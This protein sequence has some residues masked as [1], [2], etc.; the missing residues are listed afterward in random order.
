RRATVTAIDVAPR[1]REDHFA[2]RFTGYLTAPATGD[3]TI[4]GG[5][6]DCVWIWLDEQLV[7]ENAKIAP[8]RVVDRKV[9]LDAGA[10]ALR[11]VFP[12]AEGEQQRAVRWSGPGFAR[13]PIPAGALSHRAVALT[14]PSRATLAH[15]APPPTESAAAPPNGPAGKAWAELGDGACPRS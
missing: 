6:D 7:L 3:Y 9:H 5:A 11:I 12:E 2:L 4:S 10:H 8:F 15:P 14:P 13:Q 1:T